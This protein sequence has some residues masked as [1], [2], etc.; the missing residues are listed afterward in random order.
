ML[1][2]KQAELARLVK[3]VEALQMVMPMLEDEL[4][5]VEDKPKEAKR[6]P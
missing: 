4:L 5:D 2:V 1:A 3:E 6:W